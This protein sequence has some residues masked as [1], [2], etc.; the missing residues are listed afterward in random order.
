MKGNEK[1]I[2][3]GKLLIIII[4]MIREAMRPYHLSQLFS[5]QREQ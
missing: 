2:R 4:A 5:I 1:R 3:E